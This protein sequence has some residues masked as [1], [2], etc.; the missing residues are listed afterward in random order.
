MDLIGDLGGVQDIIISLFALFISPLSEHFFK[1]KFL[2]KLYLV[3]TSLH[4]LFKTPIGHPLK[5][6]K[7]KLK[8]KTLKYGIPSEIET[9]ELI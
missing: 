3:R 8:Y 4:D 2:R 1:I 6:N 7:K 5:K 9:P